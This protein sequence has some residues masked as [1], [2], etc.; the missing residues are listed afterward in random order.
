MFAGSVTEDGQDFNRKEDDYGIVPRAEQAQLADAKL[1]LVLE[2]HRT[3]SRPHDFTDSEYEG[4]IKYCQLF[5]LDNDTLWRKDS[6]GAHKLVVKP[7]DRLR[8]LRECHDQT[9]H[10]GIYAT[11]AF[12]SERFWWPS[13][14]ADIAWYVRTESKLDIFARDTNKGIGAMSEVSNE[15]PNDT[16]GSEKGTNV[17]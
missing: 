12:V 17:G 11:R 1:D 8:V 10:R 5:F 9:A 6:H 7:G 4:F 13:H 2:F 3:L 14:H 15:D 16:Y